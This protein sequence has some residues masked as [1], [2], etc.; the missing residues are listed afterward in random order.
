[1]NTRR[2]P[3]AFLL[4]LASLAWTQQYQYPFQNPSLPVEVRINN[5][6]S[7]MTL[8]EKISS[9]ST[10][11]D[12]PRLGIRG[13]GH[14]EGLHG[15]AY[16]GPGGW[17]GR[18]LKPLATTQF[19]QAVGLGETWDP[20]LLQKA[21]AMEGYEARYIF[22]SEDLRTTN[23]RG[24]QH[25]REGIVVRAP[26]ADLARDPRWGRSEESYGED[27]YL[28]GTMTVAFVRG[29]QGDDPH[30][31]LTASLMKHF[32]ANSNEDGRGGSSSNFDERLL[33]EYYSV[34][35]RMGVMDGGSRAYM[36]AYNAYNGIPMAAQPI[37]RDMTMREWGFNGI[38]CTDAGALT[39]MVTE[40]KYFPDIDQATAGAI[41]AGI[42]Q[43]LDRYR[44]GATAA[45]GKKLVNLSEI[46]ENLRGVYRVMIRLG[47]LDPPDLVPYSKI[48]G[49]TPAWDN[50]EH[51]ALA[52]KITQESIVLLKNDV[53]ENGSLK[54]SQPLLPLDRTKLESVAV[55]GP[56]ADQ[57]ALDWYSGTPPY[58]VSPLDG[59]KNKL[60]SGIKVN[61]AHD[62]SSGEAAKI[63]RAADVA[64]VVVGNHPTCNAGWAKCPLPSDGKEAIDRKSIT[65]EQE[66]L[67]KQVLA[68][69]P[70]TIVVLISS[71]PFAIQWT[72]E[73]APAIVHMAHNSQEEGNALADVLFGDY[74]PAG[75]LV[76]TW[77]IS[78][79]Q[80]PPMMDYDIRHGRTY[81]YFRQ[82][83]L[84]P[85]GYGLSYTT[86]AYSN[87]RTSAEQLKHD[88]EITMSV[89]VRNIG[90][91]AG[92]EVVE[93]YV[94]HVN[95]KVERPIEELKGFKRIA[96]QP[97][98][99]KTVSLPLKASVLAYWNSAKGA[100]EVETDQVN[101][102]V[103]S[104][105]ENIKL[106][107]VV[108][109]SP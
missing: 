23:S 35:F 33:R 52:R 84:Y 64:I 90:S 94:A 43:F 91:R 32:L 73:H 93:M 15:V 108:S 20:D 102:R 31:W 61:F 39:N 3:F 30:Y 59:I 86:F 42:D 107:Q 55:I 29:L 11:P 18:G 66:D 34:P 4:F 77:P 26:N 75:R 45:V 62:N 67:V 74:D 17:E 13:S 44:D 12:V 56:Y 36:T 1:M 7:L 71:F 96:L 54:N 28:T 10:S 2:L 19:P 103:G 38:L 76:V 89:E 80:L 101:V 104:S 16:G 109:V 83:P 9:L 79:D 25:R 70:R 97:G 14:I 98:E 47:L 87:L 41:H 57:V 6:L 100:F 53:L 81:M 60:G 50:E 78:L 95:S 22:Q 21:A 24:E 8:E 49:T 63:A 40:H 88:G 85:F 51:R 106:E 48:A 27:P 65:L 5:I 46:D 105:S 37:L 92:D 69:N 99:T 82:K 72:V 68:V 58:A